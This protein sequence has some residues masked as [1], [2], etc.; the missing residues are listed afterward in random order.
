MVSLGSNMRFRFSR[1]VLAAVAVGSVASAKAAEC[2]ATNSL[3]KPVW[4]SEASLGIKA[5]YDNNIFLSGVDSKFLPSAYPVPAGSV[6]ALK[7]VGSW[8]TAVS[9]R[10]GINFASLLGSQKTFQTLSLT[11][12]P[13]FVAYHDQGS[14][15][16]SAH[17]WLTA[18]T[19]KAESVSFCADNNFVFV[20]GGDLAPVY[21]GSLYSSFVTSS[22]RERREQIQERANISVQLD[23]EKWFLRPVASLLYYDFMTMQ[24]NPASF[25]GYQNYVDRL[26]VNGGADVGYKITPN[27]AITLGYRCGE[28]YQQKS[29]YSPYSSSDDYQR[30]LLGLE[31]KPWQWL[32]VKFQGGPDFRSFAGS[33]PMNDRQPVNYFGEAAVTAT[34]STKDTLAFKSKQWQWLSSLGK[35]PYYESLCELNYHR[36][37]TEKLG[38]DLGARLMSW[39]FTTGNLSACR[40]KDLQ[41]SATTGLSYAYSE[42]LNFNLAYASDWGRNDLAGIVNPQTREF[43]HQLISLAAKW[44]F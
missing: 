39:D 15:N 26:D 10:V 42:H 8:V 17:R 28:Q 22:A 41:Y 12:A 25:P 20:D 30:V 5:S 40:R 18:L 37:L 29:A 3:S 27:T 33:A 19:G 13:D 9:P 31:G 43:D 44:K 11:Y 1:W 38:W 7:D 24:L 16:Y 36:K 2:L 4:L 6:A 34:F 21:P 23:R 32:E 14:E 35:V